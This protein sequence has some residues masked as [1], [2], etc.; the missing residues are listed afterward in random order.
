MYSKKKFIKKF[1]A[2]DQFNRERYIQVRNNDIYFD[3]FKDYEKRK[4]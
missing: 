3:I 4:Q 1:K 2:T